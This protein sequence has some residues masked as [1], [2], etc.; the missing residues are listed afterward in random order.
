M[1][2]LSVLCTSMQERTKWLAQLKQHI[3]VM[4]ATLV[5]KPQVGLT[6][7]WY[8][9]SCCVKVQTAWCAVFYLTVPPPLRF[10]LFYGVHFNIYLLLV[11]LASLWW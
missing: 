9:D 1:E 6:H 8:F 5:I 2:K 11:V 10:T 4:S 7:M 3:K